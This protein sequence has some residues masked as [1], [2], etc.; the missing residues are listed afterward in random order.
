[1]FYLWFNFRLVKVRKFAGCD[2]TLGSP[3][4]AFEHI[5]VKVLPPED[6][7]LIDVDICVLVNV[8]PFGSDV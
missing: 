2:G 1:M 3:G 5:G 4:G 7:D 6:S 8:P